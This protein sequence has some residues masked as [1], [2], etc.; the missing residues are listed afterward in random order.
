M[1]FPSIKRWCCRLQQQ[2]L[3]LWL[4]NR[5][6]YQCRWQP[7]QPLADQL[8][9]LFASLPAAPRW[10]DTLEFVVDAPHLSYLLVPWSNGIM[11]PA[12]LRQYAALL[13]AQQQDE[14]Q[15]MAVSFL[16]SG[17][18]ENA[19][20]ALLPQALLSELQQVAKDQRL[21]LRGCRTPFSNMLSDFGRQ[22]PDNALFACIGP[23]QSSFACRFQQQWHSVFSLHLPHNELRQQLDTA[24]RLA[25]L[26]TLPRFVLNSTSGL[27]RQGDV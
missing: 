10:R 24:N 3:Q 5:L 4:N 15:P 19:F 20:A 27:R 17:Y 13:L 25:G 2:H 6:Q 26:P 9:Q 12:E 7:Q 8:A 23:Q 22:L 16:H 18:G 1:L 14:Q 11:R 21:R